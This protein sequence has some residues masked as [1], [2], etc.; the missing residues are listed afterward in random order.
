M[1]SRFWPLHTSS[2]DQGIG[3]NDNCT[4]TANANPG[5]LEPQQNGSL[6]ND[7]SLSLQMS[8]A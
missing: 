7:K 6:P 5:V 2:A 3:H 8:L 1:P 4:T